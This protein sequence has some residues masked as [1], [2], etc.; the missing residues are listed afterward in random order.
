MKRAQG[1]KD[2]HRS[3]GDQQGQGLRVGGATPDTWGRKPLWHPQPPAKQGRANQKEELRVQVC[4]E[5]AQAAFVKGT[6]ATP[7]ASSVPK[8]RASGPWS[9]MRG[10]GGAG[11]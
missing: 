1:W 8:Q 10:L 11:P 3:E 9:L 4:S 7:Q 5:G 6:K 2:P